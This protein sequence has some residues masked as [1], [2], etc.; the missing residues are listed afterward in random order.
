MNTQTY[1][2][3]QILN[4]FDEINDEWIEL[5]HKKEYLEKVKKYQS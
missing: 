5:T 1:F 2:D 3:C 4:T